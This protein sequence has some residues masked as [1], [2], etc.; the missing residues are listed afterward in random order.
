MYG[1]QDISEMLKL[2]ALML[3]AGVIINELTPN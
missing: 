3:L 1:V 2:I